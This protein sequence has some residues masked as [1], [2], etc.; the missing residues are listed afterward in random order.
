MNQKGQG[1]LE[2]SLLIVGAF[3]VA[4]I[5]VALVEGA[6]FYSDYWVEEW[7]CSEYQGTGEL[8]NCHIDDSGATV[9]EAEK[10]CVEEKPRRCLVTREKCESSAWKYCPTPIT[11]T[12]QCDG[13]V[14]NE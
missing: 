7:V 11:E 2:Y 1:A 6:P 9:C 12:R 4:A 13:V 3:S 14:I 10:R 5:V 8:I